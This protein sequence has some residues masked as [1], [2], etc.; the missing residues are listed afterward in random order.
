MITWITRIVFVFSFLGLLLY[1]YTGGTIL[2]TYVLFTVIPIGLFISAIL[3]WFDHQKWTNMV[4]L[5]S[6]SGILL[7]ILGYTAIELFSKVF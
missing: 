7:G 1:L 3:A 6:S 4:I 5:F 2:P